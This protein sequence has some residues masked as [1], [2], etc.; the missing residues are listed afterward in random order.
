MESKDADAPQPAYLTGDQLRMGVFVMIELPWLKHSFA[1][2]NFKIRT[3]AQLRG[4][5]A[6]GLDRYRYDPIRSDQ[7]TEWASVTDTASPHL[8][9]KDAPVNSSA[10]SGEGDATN[11]AN[12][13]RSKDKFQNLR[14][15]EN[16]EQV[17]KAF[18]KAATVMKNLNRS[19]YSRPRETLEELGALI[20]DMT[21]AFLN[22]PDA[23]LHVMGEK[24]GGEDVYFHSLNVTILAM[25]LAKELDFTPE[26]A[27]EMGIGAMLHDIGL[28]DIP[29]RVVKKSPGDSTRAEIH[30]RATHVDIGVNLGK[31][32]GLSDLALTVVSQHH[33]LADGSGYPLGIKVGEMTAAARLISLVN[34][35]DNLCNPPDIARTMTPHE[36][37]SHMYAQYRSKFEARSLQILIRSLG[38]H[39]PGSIVQLSDQSLAVVTAVNPKKPLRPWVLVYDENI[40]KDEAIT[41]NLEDEPAISI[42]KSIRPSK[43]SPKVAAYLNPRKRVTYFFDASSGGDSVGEKK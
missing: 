12:V 26:E 5:R 25:M 34:Y 14:R 28:A 2:N 21:D 11:L 23:T 20:G 32:I 16:V 19:I 33:E 36:A 4:L 37:L 3:D 30:L 13:Q 29:D 40:P 7:L 15:R 8:S 38:V 35:Y 22:C 6:L 27:R 24:S 42:A 9:M 41:L 39:P 17:E 43:L 1:V 10:E 31:R 18:A